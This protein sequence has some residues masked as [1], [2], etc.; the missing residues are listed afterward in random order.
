MLKNY[1]PAN[2]HQ[3]NK[4]SYLLES[5]LSAGQHDPGFLSEGGTQVPACLLFKEQQARQQKVWLEGFQHMI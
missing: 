4:L 5:N 2:N 3:Q 1:S